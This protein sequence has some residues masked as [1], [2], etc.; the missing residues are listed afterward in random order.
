MMRRNVSTKLIENCFRQP[1]PLTFVSPVGICEKIQSAATSLENEIRDLQSQIND[2]KAS[3]EAA[4][5][6]ERHADDK[7]SILIETM[8]LKKDYKI[9]R[10]L[11]E[12]IQKEYLSL[13]GLHSWNALSLQPSKMTF[14]F[15]GSSPKTSLTLTF[16]LGAPGS[17]KVAAN[18]APSLFHRSARTKRIHH[19]SVSNYLD[20]CVSKI[21]ELLGQR[22]LDS[23]AQIGEQLQY[24]EW[25]IGRLDQTVDELERLRRRYQAKILRGGRGEHS[26]LLSTFFSTQK[27]KLRVSFELSDTYP[28]TPLEV[29]MDLMDGDV[30]LDVLRRTLVKNTKHGHGQLSRTFDVIAAF[31]N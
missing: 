4:R 8:A 7:R 26:F 29:Q 2:S 27:T 1:I 17:I 10:P 6:E 15:I 22:C 25:T 31:I 24:L 9:R 30:D 20:A 28:S 13:R 18:M 14:A 19:V 12:A 11:T 21:V 16:D 3:L 23:P 5:A